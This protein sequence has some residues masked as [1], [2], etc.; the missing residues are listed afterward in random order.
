MALIRELTYGGEFANCYVIGDEGKP[1]VIVDPA[2]NRN[3]CLDA[4][5]DKHHAG[6][7]QGYLVTHGHFDHIG[8]LMSLAHQA[9][10]FMAEEDFACLD[11]TYLNGSESFG[12]PE[13]VI[14][15]NLTPYAVEDEDEIKLAGFVF[16]VIATPF[17]TKGSVCYYLESEKALFSGDTLFHLSVGRTDLPG[18]CERFKR[19]SLRK[20]LLL[21]DDTK[22][23]PGH[24]GG[25][26][27]GAERRSNGDLQGL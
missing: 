23:Y 7:V 17:H 15:R 8:G 14:V 3:G 9:P 2:T 27:I 12:L 10:V 5:I 11:N 13:P 21:P 20:L 24:E 26:T 1:C 6:H 4:Y 22:V 25:T 18:G 16:K 19:D